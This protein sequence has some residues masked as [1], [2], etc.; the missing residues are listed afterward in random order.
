[1]R[2]YLEESDLERVAVGSKATIVFDAL[3]TRQ[4]AGQ[5]ARIHPTRV[6]VAGTPA[7]EAWATLET[8]EDEAPLPIGLTANVEVIAGEAYKTLL[9]PVQA[10][11]ELAP[12]QYAVF[13]VTDGGELKLR[14]IEVGLRDFAN[15]QVVAGLEQ[16]EVVSTGTVATE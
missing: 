11:R 1:M 15:A 9:V 16:G 3:P 12:G 2:F 5:V 13:V 10:L 7:I 14:P 4:F 6:T 8:G